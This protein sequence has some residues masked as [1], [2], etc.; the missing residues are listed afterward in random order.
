MNKASQHRVDAGAQEADCR[1]CQAFR[2]LT[3]IAL[4]ALG[5]W[6]AARFIGRAGA[7]SA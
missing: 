1:P 3:L 6:L 7:R 4:L 5:G 2:G